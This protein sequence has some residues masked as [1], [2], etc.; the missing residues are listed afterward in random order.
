[1]KN[2]PT[3]TAEQNLVDTLALL[4]KIEKVF[5]FRSMPPINF[6]N[7]TMHLDDDLGTPINEAGQLLVE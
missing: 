2:L 5:L 6:I 7:I 1:M 3:L 4:K